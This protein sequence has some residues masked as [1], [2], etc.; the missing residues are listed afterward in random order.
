M[1]IKIKCFGCSATNTNIII[2]IRT[3]CDCCFCLIQVFWSFALKFHK[4]VS[5]QIKLKALK[6]K[7]KTI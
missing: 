1:K 5:V 2:E 4:S 3:L 6:A 7:K